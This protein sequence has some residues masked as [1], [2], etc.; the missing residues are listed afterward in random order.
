MN[1]SSSFHRKGLRIG[2]ATIAIAAAGGFAP[3]VFAQHEHFIGEVVTVAPPAPQVEVVGVAPSP[4]Y[5]WEAG[6]W[7]WEGGRHVWHPGRW[8]APRP[9]YYWEPHVWVHEGNGWRMRE[10]YWARR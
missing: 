4:G 5:I 10:G 7:N 8:E 1:N 6:Y 9:G 3:P 2:L